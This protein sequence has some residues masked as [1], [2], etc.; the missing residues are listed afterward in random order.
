MN[1]T[2]KLFK[3]VNYHK[4]FKDKFIKMSTVSFSTSDAEIMSSQRESKHKI[5]VCQL[6]CKENKDENFKICKDLITEAKSKGAE[7]VFLPEACDYIEKSTMA[8]IEKG[9]TLD[10]DFINQYK[11]LASDLQIWISIGSFHR[12]IKTNNQPK[13]YNTNVLLSDKG[14]IKS[15]YD[16]VHLFEINLK[17]GDV[18]TSLKESDYTIPGAEFFMPVASP[19]G[20]LGNCIVKKF[21]KTFVC[22]FKIF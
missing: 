14:E 9:E 15:I 21:I 16:K 12:K 19:V 20:T 11:K 1:F 7:M 18:L 17:N 3:S 10:G 22:V 13:V 2:L 4:Y 6:T 8:S 5:A